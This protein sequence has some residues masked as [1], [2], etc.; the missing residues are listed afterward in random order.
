MGFTFSHPALILPFKYLPKKYYS[1]TGLAIGS[2]IPDLEY[3]I[4]LNNSSTHSHTLLGVIWFD[5]PMAIFVSIIF[6]QLIRNIFIQ[7]LPLFLYQRLYSFMDFDWLSHLKKNWA[8][9]FYSILIGTLTHFLW[10]S[11]TAKGGYFVYKNS[12]SMM[13]I[14]LG[15]F[16]V[17][18]YQII[19]YTSSFI[20]LLI[21]IY[22]ALRLPKNKMVQNKIVT[23]YWVGFLFLALLFIISR[24]L[25]LD[26][27]ERSMYGLIKITI[28]SG[29]FAMILSSLFQKY[30]HWNFFK[31]R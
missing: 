13:P 11:F 29:L 26:E 8:V 20:G 21:V 7:N 6:H 15:E 24:I 31:L 18:I 19:K 2:M 23:S 27:D 10:D 12:I 9:I 30:V 5:L 1:L 22:T 3:F 4:R 17:Y 28:S 25:I 16:K 14:Y